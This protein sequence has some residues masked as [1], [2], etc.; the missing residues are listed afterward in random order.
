VGNDQTGVRK[1]IGTTDPG[2]WH[3]YVV[4]AKLTADASTG[5]VEVW[6]DGAKV[7]NQVGM[8]LLIPGDLTGYIKQGLYRDASHTSTQIVWHDGMRIW[9]V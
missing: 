5:W 7:L 3:K 9:K 6:R 4:H 2:V 8:A 1:S